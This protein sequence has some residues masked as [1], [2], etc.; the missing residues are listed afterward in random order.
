MTTLSAL[1]FS[2]NPTIFSVP[3]PVVGMD[4]AL[5]RIKKLFPEFVWDTT[6]LENNP[7]TFVEVQT[8]LEGITV[9]GRFV[10]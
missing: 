9:G 7:F 6:A 4:Q 1:G 5:F 10:S 2:W 8:L 3:L